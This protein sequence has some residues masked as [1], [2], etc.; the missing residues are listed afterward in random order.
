MYAN[1][2]EFVPRD[3]ATGGI[4]SPL[5]FSP[6]LTWGTRQTHVG[7]CSKFLI[8]EDLTMWVIVVIIF[9]YHIW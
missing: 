2:F 8:D 4:F 3:F 7:F 9:I 5:N 1:A 6:N